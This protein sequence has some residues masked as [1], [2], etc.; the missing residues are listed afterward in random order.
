MTPRP[1]GGGAGGR[2][3]PRPPA[4]SPPTPTNTHKPPPP[5][6]APRPHEHPHRPKT[7]AA[8]PSVIYAATVPAEDYEGLAN[9]LSKDKTRYLSVLNRGNV[10]TVYALDPFLYKSIQSSPLSTRDAFRD[11]NRRITQLGAWHANRHAVNHCRAWGMEEATKESGAWTVIDGADASQDEYDWRNHAHACGGSARDFCGSTI[12]QASRFNRIRRLDRVW[13]FEVP[14]A[15]VEAF[16]ELIGAVSRSGFNR[17]EW[18]AAGRDLERFPNIRIARKHGTQDSLPGSRRSNAPPG[19]APART[20][21]REEKHL[22]GS[23]FS[24]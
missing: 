3:P 4:H 18:R 15:Q 11:F 14:P 19:A 10:Y 12:D 9:R 8:P 6:P 23:L 7:H 2:P 24:L 5:P 17:A 21:D 1:A 13:E 16:R 22:Q 20:R